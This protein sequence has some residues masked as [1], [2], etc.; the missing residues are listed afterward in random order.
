MPKLTMSKADG[1]EAAVGNEAFIRGVPRNRV[2][3][4]A[5]ADCLGRSEA[6]DVLLLE[7]LATASEGKDELTLAALA[8]AR[9]PAS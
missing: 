1:I 6:W 5:A 2:L 3:P 8:V 4:A 9:A 7:A